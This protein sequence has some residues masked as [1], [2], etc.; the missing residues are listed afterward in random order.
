VRGSRPTNA[1]Q[2]ARSSSTRRALLLAWE[3][4]AGR[5]WI[6]PGGG[7]LDG[8]SDEAA[9]RREL[10]EETGLRKFTLGPLLLERTHTLPWGERILHQH[11]RMYLVRVTGFEPAPSIDLA[12]ENLRGHRW[13]TVPELEATIERIS[14]PQ[15]I[16]VLRAI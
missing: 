6:T 14:P 4:D 8:E 13:W 11:E 9:L 5:W 1:S 7:V 16:D 15:L 12:P 10:L 3:N 2:C